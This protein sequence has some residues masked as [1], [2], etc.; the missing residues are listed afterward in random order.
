MDDQRQSILA[1]IGSL[2]SRL[3]K[4]EHSLHHLRDIES[5][6]T[7]RMRYHEMISEGDRVH[8]ISNLFV[9][10]GEIDAD[11]FGRGRHDAPEIRKFLTQPSFVKEFIHNHIVEVNGDTGTGRSYQEAMTVING[12]ALLICGRWDDEYVRTSDVWRFQKIMFSPFIVNEP[13]DQSLADT[14][15][16]AVD[17]YKDFINRDADGN[18]IIP[19]AAPAHSA[20][21]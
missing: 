2:E 1:R 12:K 8:E 17:P 14:D 3:H 20:Q 13:Q 19:G 15:L 21:P 7:L 9:E 10:E 6:R 4:A 16:R 5:I 11:V 18:L